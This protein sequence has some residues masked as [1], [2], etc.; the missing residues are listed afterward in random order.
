MGQ[1]EQDNGKRKMQ[2]VCLDYFQFLL[3]S[4][5]VELQWATK[6]LRHLIVELNF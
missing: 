1:T 4:F 6:V 2:T 3:L 5:G